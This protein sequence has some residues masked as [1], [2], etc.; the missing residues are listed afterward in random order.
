MDVNYAN[1]TGI[2]DSI[3]SHYRYNPALVKT[4]IVMHINKES[5][6]ESKHKRL[7]YKRPLL[8]LFLWLEL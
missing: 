1:G 8:I 7:V 3:T 2:A 5:Y 4:P 6:G